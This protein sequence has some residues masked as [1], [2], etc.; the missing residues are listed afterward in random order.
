MKHELTDKEWE[1]IEAIR[2]YKVLP[3]RQERIKLV[4]SASVER[5]SFKRRLKIKSPSRRGGGF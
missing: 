3:T 1:L 2:N 5:T 4:Y